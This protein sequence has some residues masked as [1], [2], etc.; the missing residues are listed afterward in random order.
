MNYLTINQVEDINNEINEE[1][2]KI[3]IL[4][5]IIQNSK[6]NIE[7]MKKIL[8]EKC[9]HIRIKDYNIISE[10]S[11]YYCSVCSTSL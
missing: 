6:K 7:K 4:Q 5:T 8:K 9:N 10:H 2:T 11:E 3:K 1:I